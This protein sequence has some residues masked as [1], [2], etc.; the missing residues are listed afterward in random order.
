MKT[1]KTRE[2]VLS[3]KGVKRVSRKHACEVLGKE[4]FALFEKLTRGTAAQKIAAR[5]TLFAKNERLVGAVLAKPIFPWQLSLT[6]MLAYSQKTMSEDDFKQDGGI[7]LMRAI[8]CFD[9]RRGYRFSTYAAM[10]IAQSVMRSF[11]KQFGV[12]ANITQAWFRFRRN[13]KAL[14]DKLGRE[15]SYEEIAEQLG[16]P[17]DSLNFLKR[18]MGERQNVYSVDRVAPNGD[19]LSLAAR[20]VDERIEQPDAQAEQ[21]DL[22]SYTQLLLDQALLFGEDRECI[23]LRFGLDR[24]AGRTLEEV[25]Q[26]KKVTQ[27]R[28]RQRVD[29]GLQRL[30]E[31]RKLASVWQSCTGGSLNNLQPKK[32]PSPS[33][34][35]KKG[36]K[37]KKATTVRRMKQ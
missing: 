22:S 30:F 2:Q 34:R 13:R 26:I 32:P 18:V 14:E 33:P 21:A 11:Y 7:G 31:S 37:R 1:P 15:L 36:A 27:E 5:D 12:P 25:S 23:I 4:D 24:G 17:L 28:V 20:L 19:D 10:R 9:H 29:R 35:R 8:E 6:T 16:V 3:E